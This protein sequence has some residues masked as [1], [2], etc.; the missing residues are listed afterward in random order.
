MNFGAVTTISF[1]GQAEE[2]DLFDAL[3]AKATG[4]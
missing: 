2:Q 4:E 3:I 1:V